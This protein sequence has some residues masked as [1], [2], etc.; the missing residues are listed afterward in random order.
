MHGWKEK[1]RGG[2]MR[3]IIIKK[4]TNARDKTG[5]DEERENTQDKL[6]PEIF[7]FLLLSH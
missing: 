7:L 1:T 5:E 2:N 6:V 4:I 3:E